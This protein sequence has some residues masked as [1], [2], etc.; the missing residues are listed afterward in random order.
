MEQRQRNRAKQANEDRRQEV[1]YV[2]RD[3]A[4]AVQ[5]GTKDIKNDLRHK[6]KRDRMENA[7]NAQSLM[8]DEMSFGIFLAQGEHELKCG[9]PNRGLRYLNKAAA[10]GC[11]DEALYTLRCQCHLKQGHF[12]SAQQD[13]RRAL[14]INPYST[15]GLL[16]IAEAEYN[17]G[18]FEHALKFFYRFVSQ[19][20]VNDCDFA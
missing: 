1:I 16:V 15:K 9:D 7:Q 17:V 13:A 3:R 4:A 14:E 6:K 8:D 2:D 5:L 10:L 18:N 11:N 20:C 19:C 12:S